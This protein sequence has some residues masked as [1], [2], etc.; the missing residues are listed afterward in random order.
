MLSCTVKRI[1]GNN[2]NVVLCVYF[3]YL[4][5]I[6]VYKML[7]TSWLFAGL[8]N[9]RCKRFYDRGTTSYSCDDGVSSP[10]K[11][12]SVLVFL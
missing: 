6:I 1:N 2:E 4:S 10:V 8:T 7:F 3:V 12:S 5:C 11:F 9:G